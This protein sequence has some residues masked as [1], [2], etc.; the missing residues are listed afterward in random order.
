MALDVLPD[1]IIVKTRDEW[2]ALYLRSHKL[3]APLASIDQDSEPY[4]TGS[5]LADQLNIQ[6][7]NARQMGR[8]IPLASLNGKALD[9]ELAA[10]G[11]AP[12]FPQT[13]SQGAVIPT[14]SLGGSNVPAGTE[15]TDPNGQIFVVTTTALYVNPNG[16]PGVNIPIAAKSTGPTTNLAA[17]T[18][19]TWSAPPGGLTP[20]AFVVRQSDGSGLS[21]GRLAETDDEVRNR[22]SDAYANP[23]A[24]GNDAAYQQA[25]EFS[26]GHGVA[27][28]KAFTYPCVLGPGTT[29]FCF[30]LSPASPGST[31]IPNPTQI[32]QVRDYVVGQFPNDD[33]LCD[34]ILIAQNVDIVVSVT[35]AE[36]ADDWVD[37]VPWPP[38]YG[39]AATP[40]AFVVTAAT[41]PTSFTVDC[42]GGVRSGAIAPQAGNTIG[43]Y[44]Q[45]A[46]TF[47][48]KRILSV[49]GSG[50]WPLTIDTTNGISDTTYTPAIGQRVCPWSDSLDTLVAPVL[51][52]YGTIGPGE[53]FDNVGLF[54]PGLR[55][56]R[57]PRTPRFWPA[58]ITNRIATDILNV[59]SV[60]NAIITEGLNTQTTVGTPGVSSYLI[61]LGFISAFPI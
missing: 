29:A 15:C 38:Y 8:T 61:E 18:K 14:T 11:L 7:E 19:L 54:D 20:Q 13:G 21:G 51:A 53:Q 52:Y 41:S 5:A 46:G 55:L 16:V 30:T 57:S 33:G 45:T 27:V 59:D 4:V 37:A 60:E 36:G 56:R 34:C 1:E 26:K 32:Q 10:L 6:S 28:Q 2:L 42:L 25:I 17:G 24:A 35:W 47:E 22:I 40:S 23:A 49:S 31:R 44:N 48:E 39:P 12:R 43:V 3:R 9:A 50:P 58:T